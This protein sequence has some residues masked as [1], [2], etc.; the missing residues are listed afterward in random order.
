MKRRW[1]FRG[2]RAGAL[3]KLPAVDFGAANVTLA[4]VQAAS[5]PGAPVRFGNGTMFADWG[6]LGNDA[7]GDCAFAGSDH[8]HMCWTGIGNGGTLSAKFTKANTLSDYS[9][10]TGYDPAD[11]STDQGTVVYQLMDYRRTVG[12]VDAT[13]KR[14][15]IDLA[16]RL[17]RPFDWSEFI[18]AVW[19]FKA[20][21]IGTLIPQSAMEQFNAGQP[22][23]Y[24]GDRNIEGGHYI[25]GV[26]TV[27]RDNEVTVITWGKRQR[28]TRAFFEA[29]VDELW[30]PLSQEAMARIESAL[31]LVD[32]AKVQTVARSLGTADA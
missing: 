2:R 4:D 1:A 25:P 20:V 28:M 10:L 16:V 8:E 5:L 15:K 22:W 6:M 23:D 32:W 19:A 13:G 29:Y 14:H 27:D 7:V 18:R 30:I 3:G 9:A 11:P 26:G 17:P 31:S 21:A 24:V 12:V